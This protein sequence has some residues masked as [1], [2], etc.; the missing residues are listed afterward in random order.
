MQYIYEA[1]IEG[2]DDGGYTVE[3]PDWGSA[4]EG[5]NLEEAVRMG[6]DLLEV[7]VTTALVDD[8]ELPHPVFGHELKKNEERLLLT[9]KTS[10]EEAE[11]IWPWITTGEAAEI[12]GVTPARVRN[13]VLSGA[14]QAE[15]NGRDLW[16]S[17]A[18]VRARMKSSPQPG[19]PR[20]EAVAA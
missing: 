19:R 14:L 4:T 10:R 7:E 20:K 3:L 6:I 17:R 9:I 5:E 16:V 18:D 8:R 15:K 2:Y 13:L 11:K 1:I 12:L